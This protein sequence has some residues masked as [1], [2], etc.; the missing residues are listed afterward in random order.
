MSS[1]FTA[2]KSQK[3]RKRVTIS[4]PPKKRIAT[5][6]A[7]GRLSSAGHRAKELAIKKKQRGNGNDDDSI[8]G[9]ESDR[10]GGQYKRHGGLDN[11]ELSSQ[12][13]D[14]EH[15]GETIAE[16]RLRLAERYLESVKSD[17]QEEYG[18]DAAEIDREILAARL[19]EDVAESK[20]K[21]Y[22][23]ITDKLN[24]KTAS[25][26]L[27]KTNT[28]TVT[29]VATHGDHAY[30][31]T[32]DLM[33]SKWKL[34]DLPKDQHPQTAR[35]NTAKPSV[36]L[37]KQPQ[38]VRLYRG[39]RHKAKDKLYKGHTAAILAV[40]VSSDGKLVV[41]GGA[42]HKIIV[43]EAET[44]KPLRVFTQHRSGVTG[45]VFRRGTNQ[46]YSSS[47]DRVVKVW[48]L[49]EMAFV[50]SLF[51][52]EE[53]VVDIDALGQEKCVTV[54][55]RDRTARFWK[56]IDEKQLVFR[57]GAKDR[58]P[59]KGIDPRSQ[60]QEGSIDRV[61]M[62][63]DE[64]F[65]TGGDSG[66][67]TL[68]SVQ[69]K[70]PLFAV[71]RAHGVEQS[72]CIDDVSAEAKPDP[73]K[74]IPPP[75][76]RWI[77]ALKTVPYSD[78]I[79]S[80]SWDGYIR[81]WRLSED[82]K[83]LEAVGVL[84]ATE[85]QETTHFANDV[86][87]LSQNITDLESS[88]H[89]LSDSEAPDTEKQSNSSLVFPSLPTVSSFSQKSRSSPP[90]VVKGFINDI[91]VF[92]RGSRGRDGLCVVAAVGK[93]HKFGRWMK[94]ITGAKNGGV[95]FEI[96]RIVQPLKTDLNGTAGHGNKE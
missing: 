58:K 31:V 32:K 50:A 65:V 24:F 78:L 45:L 17:V 11:G 77:T 49:D 43:Y 21:V 81:V 44:L 66:T 30:F 19:Q 68:W 54:G 39:N 85:K 87:S 29:A 40:A 73:G 83:C 34:Q 2:P 84:G 80:G 14:S 82:K 56:V 75:Q 90:F 22:K 27:F 25:H 3:K 42:D 10:N 74:V 1:F 18:F 93:E 76:P 41:T 7:G 33:L 23:Q 16:K 28:Q 59:V 5:S 9:S 94:P 53:A 51:G 36:P 4:D 15:E 37:K 91:S 46:M 67:I 26:A 47:R 86:S 71:P 6:K 92:E 61:A 72:L 57:G 96:P 8:S 95:V 69:K 48:S 20:G 63:D 13:S 89:G 38:R 79:L 62:I 12:D 60:A 35:K 52:H 64:L 55:S 88:F 70:N